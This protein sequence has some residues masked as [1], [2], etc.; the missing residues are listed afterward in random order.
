MKESLVATE[1]YRR[2]VELLEADID[3]ELVALDPQQGNCFGFNSVAKE[4][5]RKLDQPRS[6]DELRTGLLADYEVGE[7][8]CAR[9]LRELIDQMAA[10][11]LIERVQR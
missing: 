3:D 8:E 6:F 10:A 2:V 1:V 5:W 4:I 7:A 9:D 11:K